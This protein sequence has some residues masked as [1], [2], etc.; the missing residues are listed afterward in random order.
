MKFKGRIVRDEIEGKIRWVY[1]WFCKL[2]ESIEF[3]FKSSG[4][5]NEGCDIMWLDLG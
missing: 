1:V 4:G 2:Y 5:I 3:Y